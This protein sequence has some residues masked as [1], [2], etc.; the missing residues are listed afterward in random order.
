M[1]LPFRL[2][3][4]AGA[5]ERARE[6]LRQRRATQPLAERS[7]GCVFRN[8]GPGAQSAGALID[9]SGLKGKAQV[10]LTAPRQ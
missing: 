8:P 5:P 7:V 2:E 4:D 9:R 10:S 3:K 1:D 6:C